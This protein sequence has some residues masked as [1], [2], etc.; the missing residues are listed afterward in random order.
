MVGDGTVHLGQGLGP[1]GGPR[2]GLGLVGG[3]VAP[4][5]VVVGPL[6]DGLDQD[7]PAEV[8][9]I[10]LVAR[11]GQAARLNRVSLKLLEKL[12]FSVIL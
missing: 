6:P 8:V 10:A 3:I 11:D 5:G 7:G 1:R 9:R 4:P 2:A 12:D